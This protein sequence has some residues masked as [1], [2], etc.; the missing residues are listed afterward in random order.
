ML[1]LPSTPVNISTSWSHANY[2][3]SSPRVISSK[4]S[5]TASKGAPDTASAPTAVRREPNLT[6]KPPSLTLSIR[7]SRLSSQ[8]FVYQLSGMVSFPEEPLNLSAADGFGYLAADINQTLNGGEFAIVRKLGWGPRSSTWLV[9]V[10]GEDSTEELDF[11]NCYDSFWEKSIHGEHLCFVM[12][13]HG[14]PFSCVVQAAANSGR[15]GL[16]VHVVQ[17]T[18]SVI[19]EA[20]GKSHKKKLENIMF[21]PL[22]DEDE[23]LEHIASTPP[24][25]TQIIDGLP[26]AQSQ[27]LAIDKAEWDE[28]MSKVCDWS[29]LL[30]GF[31]HVQVP[32]Y[33]PERELNYSSAPETLLENPACELATDVWMLGCL[34]FQLLTGQQLFTATGTGAERLGEIRDVLKASIPEAWLGDGHVQGLPDA[35]TSTQSL[36]Q[37]LREVLSEDEASVASAFLRKCLVIDPA[38]RTSAVDLEVHDEWVGEGSKC[39]CCYRD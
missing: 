21:E 19:L 15:A 4:S 20:L 37:R 7:P 32:P 9:Q 36:E 16:P 27:P 35:S 25:T 33:A 23:L 29:L 5:L 22:T 10:K 17:Y 11:P 2:S 3:P 8:L 30:A 12:N 18:T 34:V 26:A 13:P 24:A 28:P 6:F 38:G 14:L 31:G 39:S 1:H